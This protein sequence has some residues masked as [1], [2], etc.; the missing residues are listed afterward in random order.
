MDEQEQPTIQQL[1]SMAIAQV[2]IGAMLSDVPDEVL[3]EMFNGIAVH[4]SVSKS[5][6]IAAFDSEYGQDLIREIGE[7]YLDNGSN[8]L[9]TVIDEFAKSQQIKIA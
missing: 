8:M 1:A 9:S 5:I 3:T 2:A 6:F 4:N 7:K